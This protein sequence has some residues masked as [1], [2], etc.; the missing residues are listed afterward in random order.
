M[1]VPALARIQVA[2][3]IA[4][5]MPATGRI[6]FLSQRS[7]FS[8]DL[9]VADAANGK[10]VRKLTSTATDPHFSSIQSLDSSGANVGTGQPNGLTPVEF[11]TRPSEGQNQNRISS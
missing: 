5:A 8:T 3:I 9:Y 4:R 7:F 6:A 10:I 11:A 2:G 1:E